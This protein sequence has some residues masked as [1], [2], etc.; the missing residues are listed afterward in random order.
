[1]LNPLKG[2]NM[3][4]KWKISFIDHKLFDSIISLFFPKVYT[5]EVFDKD[6]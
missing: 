2:Q 5:P 6:I 3:L 1:M 4:D